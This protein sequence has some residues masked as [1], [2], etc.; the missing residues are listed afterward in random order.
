MGNSQGST[1]SAPVMVEGIKTATK[2]KEKD[3]VIS[4]CPVSHS[5]S[6]STSMKCPFGYGKK[7]AT[8]EV[9]K[10]AAIVTSDTTKNDN[11]VTGSGCPV[12]YKNPNV[13][14]V[15]S[16]HCK[17]RNIVLL[18]S[19]R[20]KISEYYLLLAYLR[21]TDSIYFLISIGL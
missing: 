2:D 19:I 11:V 12:K 15:S 10:K 18:A 6:T 20:F 9:P 13:Y 7:T 14:N 3:V 21:Y 8:D 16:V 5:E 4:K 17:F 1:P